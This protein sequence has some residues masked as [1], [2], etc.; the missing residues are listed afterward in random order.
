MFHFLFLH[1]FFSLGK[2]IKNDASRFA[3]TN[4]ENQEPGQTIRSLT[5][6][7]VRQIN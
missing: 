1:P 2:I 7:L 6:H 4:P 5:L 3:K